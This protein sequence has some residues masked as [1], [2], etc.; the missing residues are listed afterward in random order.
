[1]RIVSKDEG[2]DQLEAAIPSPAIPHS[3]LPTPTS[4]KDYPQSVT[5]VQSDMQGDASLWTARDVLIAMLRDIDSGEIPMPDQFV[6]IHGTDDEP[7]RVRFLQSGKDPVRLLGML[8]KVVT[9]LAG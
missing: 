3:P 5:E 4:F 9:I 2:K 7:R 1:M 8:L 6:I